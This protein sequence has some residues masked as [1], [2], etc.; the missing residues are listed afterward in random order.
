M[1]ES[2][3]ETVEFGE[4]SLEG[5]TLRVDTISMEAL[6]NNYRSLVEQAHGGFGF[7]S[8]E[9]IVLSFILYLKGGDLRRITMM[10]KE[11]ADARLDEAFK[12]IGASGSP[13]GFYDWSCASTLVQA[14]N[15]PQLKI[16]EEVLMHGYV[17]FFSKMIEAG[18]VHPDHSQVFFLREHVTDAVADM[19]GFNS[20]LMPFYNLP[21]AVQL[22]HKA[23]IFTAAEG[24]TL[25]LDRLVLG[26]E[27]VDSVDSI[28]EEDRPRTAVLFLNPVL[29]G[30]DYG[31]VK[32]T[33]DSLPEGGR[34][35]I[36]S[37]TAFY[38]ATDCRSKEA[39]EH[40]EGLDI[41]SVVRYARGL[42][43][44][45]IDIMVA[46]IVKSEPSDEVL[47]AYDDKGDRVSRKVRRSEFDWTHAVEPA[48]QFDERPSVPGKQ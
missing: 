34:L 17:M 10:S 48:V 23:R 16:P 35:I 4:F 9:D 42:C 14:L 20:V 38:F 21:L 41:R 7:E 44:S 1:R 18:A 11:E 37:A 29:R 28:P 26:V 24:D 27:T 2:D 19:V 40:L 45:S 15:M 39:R 46:D 3:Y 12:R 30:T 8:L 36:V 31:A 33:I 32:D 5:G 6:L 47:I 22:Y 25:S 43:G 13:R